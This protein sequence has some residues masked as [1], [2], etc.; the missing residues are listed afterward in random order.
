[1]YRKNNCINCIFA[2]IITK[3]KLKN[4]NEFQQLNEHTLKV[5]HNLHSVVRVNF[6]YILKCKKQNKIFLQQFLKRMRMTLAMHVRV[7]F[8]ING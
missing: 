7:E 2:N 1:M 3:G 6:N 4:F 8:Y 5:F